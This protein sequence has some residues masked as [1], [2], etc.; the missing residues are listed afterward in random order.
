MDRWE[1]LIFLSF[2]EEEQLH[3]ETK[4]TIFKVIFFRSDLALYL[5]QEF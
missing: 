1:A 5:G 4:D 3:R 2:I